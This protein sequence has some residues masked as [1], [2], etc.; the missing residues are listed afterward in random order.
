MWMLFPEAFFL[1]I[2]LEKRKWLGLVIKLP[3]IVWPTSLKRHL[4]RLKKHWELMKRQWGILPIH[5]ENKYLGKHNFILIC[6]GN[7][8]FNFLPPFLYSTE[9]IGQAK[10]YLL[11][12]ERLEKA[13]F[14]SWDGNNLSAFFVANKKTCLDWLSRVQVMAAYVGKSRSH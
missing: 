13:M 8:I 14:N 4:A 2:I 9:K 12:F 7:L 6:F 10:N 1:W 3:T 5:W 11:V